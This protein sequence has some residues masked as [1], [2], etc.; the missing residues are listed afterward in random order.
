MWQ[1]VLPNGLLRTSCGFYKRY[2]Q[3]VYGIIE[4]IKCMP[5]IMEM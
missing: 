2:P 5:W 4:Y 3:G 1:H